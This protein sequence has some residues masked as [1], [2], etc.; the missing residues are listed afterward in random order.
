M[1]RIT[2]SP[3]WY[4]LTGQPFKSRMDELVYYLLDMKY[5]DEDTEKLAEWRLKLGLSDIHYKDLR[6]SA[7]WYIGIYE[8]LDADHPRV[9]EVILAVQGVMTELQAWRLYDHGIF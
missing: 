2:P 3:N 6:A 4:K 7:E 9:M 5:K 1:L 8:Q